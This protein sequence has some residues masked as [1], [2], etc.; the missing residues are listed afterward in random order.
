MASPRAS[1]KVVRIVV[2]AVVAVT[3]GATLGFLPLSSY[4][5]S[6][7]DA[8]AVRSEIQIPHQPVVSAQGTILMTDV[9]LMQLTPITWLMDQFNS[10]V[11]IYPADEIFGG[12]NPSQ[13]VQLQLGQMADSKTQAVLAAYNYVHRPYTLTSGAEIAT[14][15]SR[16]DSKLQPGDLITQV[17][18]VTVSTVARAVSLVEAAGPK[19]RLTILREGAEVGKP[20]RLVVDATK[21]RAGTKMIV[22][23]GLQ[24]GYSLS[25]ADPVKISTGEIG[26]P[27]AGLAFTL[28]ILQALGAISVPHSALFAATGTINSSGVV[29]DVGGVRQKAIAV[30]RHGATVFLVPPQ[31]VAAARSAHEPKL[32][33][34]GVSTLGQAISYLRAHSLLSLNQAS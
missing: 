29:G 27:S 21:Y 17:N 16:A 8:I 34:V 12:S 2:A 23:V 26:G 13:L 11:N 9:I 24:P 22:G 28:G 7:G 15:T 5:F 10:T 14:T 30:A 25:L 3:I 19:V 4:S 1:R 18:G 32:T 6:P 20:L 31:E 33:V